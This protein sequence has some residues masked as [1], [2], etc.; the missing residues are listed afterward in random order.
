VDFASFALLLTGIGGFITGLVAAG[1][2]IANRRAQR[3]D[4]EAVV[5]KANF[6]ELRDLYHQVR[7]ERD[8]YRKALREL[9]AELEA[10]RR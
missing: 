7:D 4:D 8:A 10:W 1:V 6:D 9:E 2:A 3:D 5:R